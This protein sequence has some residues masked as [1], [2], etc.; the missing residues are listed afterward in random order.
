MK[1]KNMLKRRKPSLLQ[2]RAVVMEKKEKMAYTLMQTIN[3]IR[4]EKETK[5]KTKAK[6]QRAGYEK[7]KK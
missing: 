7:K 4:N 3:T 2:R 6:E 1:D 5:R